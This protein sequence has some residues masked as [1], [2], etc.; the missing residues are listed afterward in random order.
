MRI[1]SWFGCFGIGIIGLVLF[2]AAAIT[3]AV[4]SEEPL[5]WTRVCQLTSTPGE[6]TIT[7]DDHSKRL[8]GIDHALTSV[9]AGHEFTVTCRGYRYGRKIKLQCGD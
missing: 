4:T 2:L 6:A 5:E 9:L 3:D 7:C 8:T 1:I